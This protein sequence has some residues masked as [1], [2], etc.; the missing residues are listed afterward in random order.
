M[1]QIDDFLDGNSAPVNQKSTIDTFLDAAPPPSRGFKGWAGDALGVA[2]RG[3]IAVPEAVVGLADI[4]TGGRVG[5][6]LENEGGAVGL[7]F[8]QAKEAASDLFDSDATK[9]QNQQFQQAD[10]IVEKAKV[11]LSNPSMIGRAV[12]ESI[13]SMLAGGVAARGVQVAAKAG[14]VV[15][16]ALGEGAVAAGTAAEQI[17]QE[18]EDGRLTPAQA[19]LAAGTGVATAGF[20]AV[21]GRVAQKL[22][23]GDVETM[24]AQ[25]TKGM[26]ADAGTAAARAAT[27]PLVQQQAVKSIP[28]RV[29]EGAIAEGFLEELPQSV[30]EQVFQNVA[31]G[32]DWLTDVDAAV[33]MGVLTGG[34]MGSAAAGYHGMKQPMAG[35]QDPVQPTA[36]P[37]ATHVELVT[38]G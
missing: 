32:K 22:G 27:N 21:G 15:A 16:G 10:G 36:A 18:T 38:Y 30:A 2:A 35:A 20:G 34:A 28:R 4:A 14:P 6:A 33:V 1:S 31:L 3:A 37:A 25:G 17:R 29:I 23:I 11:A 24:L 12:A 13:P 26:A 19:A 5:K 7:R 9:A 8:K